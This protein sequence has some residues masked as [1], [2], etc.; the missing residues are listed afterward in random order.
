MRLQLITDVANDVSRDT[1]DSMRTEP[2][3]LWIDADI[4]TEPSR[5]A[6]LL[7]AQMHSDIEIVGVSLSGSKQDKRKEE[8][9]QILR[10]IGATGVKVLR[11]DEVASSDIS[12]AAPDTTLTM[13][14]LTNIARLILDEAPFGRLFCMAGMLRH[15]YYRNIYLGVDPNIAADI[16]AARVVL[17]Q[18]ESTLCTFEA[19][20]QLILDERTEKK[21]AQKY[22]FLKS[23]IEGYRNYLHEK[24]TSE[25]SSIYLGD[26]LG[27]SAILNI[28]T[29][30]IETIEFV[31]Q[32]D[33]SMLPNHSIPQTPEP[34]LPV[35]NI[36]GIPTPTVKQQFIRT[37]DVQRVYNEY[38]Q[39]I[40]IA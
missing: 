20:A 33:G 5:A 13:G 21:Q 38:L 34:I 23:R 30:T 22:P 24:F 18:Y 39:A 10:E 7:F 32:S 37:V 2:I 8:T 15:I 6:A 25:F 9:E 16:D 3:R 36:N 1:L 14:P 35:E 12:I 28:P 17:S 26:L 19:S 29:T 40:Q 4:G 27:I 31:F 11:G